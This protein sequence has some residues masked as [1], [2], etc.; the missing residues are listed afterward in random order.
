MTRTSGVAAAQSVAAIDFATIRVSV[1][2]GV[3][4]VV[5]DN[6]PLNL[7]DSALITDLRRFVEAVRKDTTIRVIVVAS[8]DPEFFSAHGDA[9]FVSEEG[10]FAKL[11][12]AQ[13]APLNPMQALHESLRTLPQVTI[14]KIA[15][16]ARGGGHELLMSLDMRFAAIGP[17]KVAQPETTLGIVPGGGGTQYLT[18]LTGR[19]RALEAILGGVLFNAETAERYGLVNRALPADALD[20]YVD[21]LARRIAALGPA[22]IDGARRSIDAAFDH[23]IAEG[24]RIEN[25]ELGKLFTEETTRRT[26]DLLSRGYQTR[27]GERDL[28]RILHE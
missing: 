17:T 21:S 22:V 3:A 18:R 16:I 4:N 9:R 10:L 5:L 11:I 25:E 27:E 19:A 6:P 8:A 28:E 14:G 23:D 12:R 2:D 24:M 13:D 7:L 20:D 1:H 15:G 26:I